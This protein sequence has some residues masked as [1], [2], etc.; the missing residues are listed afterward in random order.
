[1]KTVKY[2]LGIFLILL[3]FGAI[4]QH[5][6]IPAVAFFILGLVII[7]NVSEQLKAKLKIWQNKNFRYVSYAVFFL[8]GASFIGKTNFK[9][10]NKTSTEN[11]SESYLTKKVSYENYSNEVEKNISKLPANKLQ[12]REKWLKELSQNTTYIEL[13]K[14]KTVSVDYLLTLTAI[15]DA[16][17]NSIT[18][19]GKSQFQ[20]TDKIASKVESSKDGKSKMQFVVNVASLSLKTNGGLPKEIIEIFERYRAKYNLYSKESSTFYNATGKSENLKVGFNIVYTF[21]LLDPKNEKVLDAIYETNFSD[22][23]SWN[24]DVANFDYT[25]MSNKKSYLAY[26]EDVY[27]DSKYLPDM[28]DKDLWDQY[29]PD[30][31]TRIR[32]L[33]FNKDCEGL[34]NEFNTADKN[35]QMQLK[36]TGRTNADL[37]DF[38][39]EQMRAIGCYK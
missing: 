17:K 11:S 4:V 21:A 3:S 25:Y 15:S 33:I 9:S 39:D 29:A 16:I 22:V 18:K 27:Q 7:P 30:V 19:D 20:I 34:Q 6:I 28:N 37:M 8:F 24:D 10:D 31:K 23:G 2:I 32:L 14:N 12:L 13:A 38:V 35:N 26:L 36:R 1:M 5:K